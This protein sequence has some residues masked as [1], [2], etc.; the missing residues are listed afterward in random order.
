MY[1]YLQ[2][3]FNRS[4]RVVSMKHCEQPPQAS[5]RIGVSCRFLCLLVL[6]DSSDE[7]ARSAILLCSKHNTKAA[8]YSKFIS[9]R[10]HST[11]VLCVFVGCRSFEQIY[12]IH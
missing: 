6:M 9:I 7:P 1:A 10:A 11:R 8:T 2:G 4:S 3:L 12:C 5:Q